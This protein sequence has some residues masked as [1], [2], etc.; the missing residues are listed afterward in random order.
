MT[1]I[2]AGDLVMITSSILSEEFRSQ[3]IETFGRDHDLDKV[4]SSDKVGKVLKVSLV[5]TTKMDNMERWLIGN[6]TTLFVNEKG[7]MLS[8]LYVREKDVELVFKV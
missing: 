4:Y 5:L 2:N 3:V 7:N 8:G 6:Q 1:E